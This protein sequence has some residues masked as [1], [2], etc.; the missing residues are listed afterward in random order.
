MKKCPKC[1]L[2]LED[3]AM[4]CSYCGYDF[5][6]EVVDDV[7]VASE[8]VAEAVPEEPAEPVYNQYTEESVQTPP[9]PYQQDYNPYAAPQGKYCPRCGN[10]CDPLA[11]ICVKCG[12]PFGA[13]PQQ[14]VDDNPKTI[15]KVV[16]FFFPIVA[17]ILYFVEKDKKPVSAKAYG[18]WGLIGL[19]VNIGL[20]I[21]STVLTT[22]L[23]LSFMGSYDDYYYYYQ[24]L[25]NWF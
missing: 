3:S 9:P 14:N 21:I 22:I 23:G 4:K 13:V 17:L 25:A 11:A 7:V 5:A 15:L 6:E 24:I 2:N 12:M 8:P 20:S 19:A 16:C 18:K 1:S 10:L